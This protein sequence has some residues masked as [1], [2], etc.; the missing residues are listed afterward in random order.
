MSGVANGDG[1]APDNLFGFA[2]P[3]GTGAGGSTADRTPRPDTSVPD[4]DSGL[5][6][7]GTQM[8]LSY[9]SGPG[10]SASTNQ[11]GQV[12]GSLISPGDSADYASHG[13][14]DGDGHTMADALGRYPW[15]AQPGG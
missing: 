4:G 1:T 7:V 9:Q 6:G 5:P 13:P 12:D 10:E 11:P 8:H 2:L 14:H 15:Q 3:D